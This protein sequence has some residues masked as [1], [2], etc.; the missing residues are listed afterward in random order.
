MSNLYDEFS[1]EALKAMALEVRAKL[2]K[3]KD[4]DGETCLW[5]KNFFPMAEKNFELGFLCF[6]CNLY[7]NR[8][9]LGLE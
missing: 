8:V 3:P 7:V 9:I 4:P 5:C 1:P 2:A 6:S